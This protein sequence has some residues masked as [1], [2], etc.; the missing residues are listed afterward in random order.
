LQIGIVCAS[1]LL[2]ICFPPQN[3]GKKDKPAFSFSGA[4]YFHR[5]SKDDMHE[6][7]PGGQEDLKRWSDMV[8]T[9]LYKNVK[10][11]EGLAATANTVLETYKANKAVVVRT[12]SV[13]RTPT[14]PAEHLI[15]V[16]FPR[17]DLIE[18]VFARFKIQD[19]AGAAVIYSHRIY[20]TKA[21]NDMSTWLK[22]NGQATEKTLMSMAASPAPPHKP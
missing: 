6:Y 18:A 16:L 3:T 10:D 21:G 17:K 4:E 1:L 11:G 12:D 15:V 7:T 14:K 9:R 13:P 19:G 2:L 5:Y 22:K 8:T 20:G